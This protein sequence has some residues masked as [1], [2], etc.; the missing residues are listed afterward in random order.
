MLTQAAVLLPDGEQME[1]LLLETAPGQYEGECAANTQGTYVL[2]VTQEQAGNVL[3]VQEGGAVAGFSGEYDLRNI[4]EDD[5]QQLCQLTG[6]R[7]LTLADSFWDTPIAPAVSRRSLQQAFCV[8]ALCLF[9]MDI[10]LRKLPWEEAASRW[11]KKPVAAEKVSIPK[12]KKAERNK[13][14]KAQS[15][16]EQNARQTANALLEAKRARERK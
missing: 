7:V 12:T 3:R 15:T 13:I 16:M 8:A 14:P 4:P 1:I 9:L 2:R 10:A 6:G 11:L 5:L